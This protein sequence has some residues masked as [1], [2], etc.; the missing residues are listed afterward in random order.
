MGKN[1]S[2]MGSILC[3]GCFCDTMETRMTR[4]TRIFRD[5][6]FVGS[7]LGAMDVRIQR[8]QQIGTDFF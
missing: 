5:V 2:E 3:V 4:M 6:S 1:D 8:I 7:T